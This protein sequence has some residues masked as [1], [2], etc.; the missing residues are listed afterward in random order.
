MLTEDFAVE[1]VLSFLGLSELTAVRSVCHQWRRL[2]PL[3]VLHNEDHLA[4]LGKCVGT[5]ANEGYVVLMKM[6]LDVRVAQKGNGSDVIPV[7]GAIRWQLSG[8]PTSTASPPEPAE[9]KVGHERVRGKLLPR[10]RRL[11]MVGYLT[12]EKV[13][14]YASTGPSELLPCISCGCLRFVARKGVDA[15]TCESCGHSWVSHDLSSTVL[16]HLLAMEYQVTLPRSLQADAAF[17]VTMRGFGGEWCNPFPCRK[18]V[19]F[20][21]PPEEFQGW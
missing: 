8:G 21:P 4:L 9:K 20:Q 12:V 15:T 14:D 1:T 16:G 6:A 11:E 2:A 18:A 19:P 17:T 13:C 5:G 10:S 3:A 7:E